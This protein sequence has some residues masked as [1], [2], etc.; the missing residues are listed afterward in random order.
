MKLPE[1]KVIQFFLKT[2][3]VICLLLLCR[4]CRKTKRERERY[5]VVIIL[6]GRTTNMCWY[7]V[8]KF[9][10]LSVYNLR[11]NLKRQ[12][13]EFFFLIENLE[14]KETKSLLSITS[15]KL[16]CQP[17]K[18]NF[19]IQMLINVVVIVVH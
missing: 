14:K 12:A 11:A 10:F 7:K 2:I 6:Q 1:Q 8:G 3:T 16:N 5:L 17:P 4:R 15:Q 19:N 18:S 13:G 9:L